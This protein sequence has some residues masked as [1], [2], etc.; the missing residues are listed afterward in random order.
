V[1]DVRKLS[2]NLFVAPQ[3]SPAD[4]AD[5]DGMQFRSILCNRPDAEEE[6]QPAYEKI[7]QQADALGMMCDFQ[8]VN[9]SVIS[10]D[11]VDE[12]VNRLM[13]L[14]QPVLAYCRT[15]TRCSVLWALSQA[16]NQSAEQIIATAAEAGYKLESLKERIEERAAR[17]KAG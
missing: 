7:R 3:L 1:T 13:D 2:D 15:G 4:V 5:I 14:P 17:K 8:P 16:G 6:N 10:D 9:G 12:F 11:D